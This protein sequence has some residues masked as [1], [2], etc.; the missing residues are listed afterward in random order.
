MSREEKEAGREGNQGGEG[1]KGRA[2]KMG[3]GER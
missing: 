3:V 2:M 1:V